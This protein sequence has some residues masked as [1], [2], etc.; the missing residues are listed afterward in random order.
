MVSLHLVGKTDEAIEN[1]KTK[2]DATIRVFLEKP[3]WSGAGSNRRHMDFQSIALP[4][5]LPDL[6]LL[7]DTSQ[8]AAYPPGSRILP[9]STIALVQ[10]PTAQQPPAQ[11]TRIGGCAVKRDRSL[12]NRS[13]LQKS[14]SGITPA[15][16]AEPLPTRPIVDNRRRFGLKSLGSATGKTGHARWCLIASPN[17]SL[18]RD[19][20]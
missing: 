16:F 19:V 18:D 12:Q 8:P 13:D 6:V 10:Q 5:E 15:V 11:V 9:D 2:K 17:G 14:T 3:K 7:T 1:L 20:F 4:T